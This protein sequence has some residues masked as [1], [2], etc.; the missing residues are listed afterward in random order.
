[1]NKVLPFVAVL[2]FS[3]LVAGEEFH[4]ASEKSFSEAAK[5]AVGGDVIV[6]KSGTWRDSRL[7]IRASG[8][9]GAPITI[10][11]ETPG[12]V[13]FKG[14]SRIALGG[15]HIVVDG[16]WF[17]N[18]TGNDSIELRYDSKSLARDCRIT[19]C[20]VT[21]NDT[22]AKIKGSSRFLSVYGSGHR[23]DHC[24]FA[25]KS[26]EGATAVV[27]LADGDAVSHQI[28]HN[29]FGPRERLGKNGGETI[30][31]GDSKTSM[32]VASCVVENNLF[33]KCD[34]EAE[35]I[36][37]KSCKNIY[38]NNHFVG[39]SGTLTLRHGNDC[40]VENNVFLGNGARGTGGVRV[41][42]EGHVVTGNHFQ[43]L[44]GEDERSAMCFMMG[45]PD[46]PANGYFQVKRARIT[47]NRFL[48]CEHNI[49]IGMEGHSKA[50][51]PPLES[52][53][54]ANLIQTNKGKA[55]EILCDSSGVEIVDNIIGVEPIKAAVE[56]LD[57]GSVGA[58]WWSN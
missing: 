53:I 35:C 42:G 41:I 40:L 8:D 32:M 29:H 9:L 10:K 14:D 25:G 26:S 2:F 17:Q 16:L 54:S 39:V 21:N 31:I 36:S 58:T 3:S 18:P 44:S 45:I 6:L 52:V 27:W 19:N 46:S 48:N 55:F 43:D 22:K 20:A 1:M 47:N 34:G 24:Y 56:T 33:E 5:K 12:K 13:I 15:R 38:R 11:A 57:P 49:L 50:I 37:N 28:D 51:L 23:I 4:V 7:K 30:R